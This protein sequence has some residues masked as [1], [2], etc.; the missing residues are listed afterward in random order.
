[1]HRPINICA[2]Q[3]DFVTC[4]TSFNTQSEGTI[5]QIWNTVGRLNLV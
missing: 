4:G 2:G 5:S 3:S 1:M